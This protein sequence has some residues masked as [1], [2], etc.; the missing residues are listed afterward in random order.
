MVTAD[1]EQPIRNSNV[2]RFMLDSSVFVCVCG[3]GG[4]GARSRLQLEY[5]SVSLP[6]S[7]PRHR[8]HWRGRGVLVVTAAHRLQKHVH[9]AH[10]RAQHTLQLLL[11]Q[12]AE[13][14]Y[15]LDGGLEQRL[16]QGP[17]QPD[18]LVLA[19]PLLTVTREEH[20]RQ[21]TARPGHRHTTATT[22]TGHT[23]A[24]NFQ[25]GGSRVGT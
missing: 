24:E 21:K 25:H 7:T 20:L 12:L 9:A 16:C 17:A 11:P 13:V 4:G 23:S 14:D 8:T 19:Q 5:L 3:G 10:E 18:G 6:I 22:S 1:R 2:R 15:V